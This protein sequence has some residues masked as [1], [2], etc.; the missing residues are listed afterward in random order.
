MLKEGEKR[1]SP[2]LDPGEIGRLAMEE[3]ADGVHQYSIGG[4]GVE[5]A[6]F[7][8]RQDPLD[9]TV[10]LVTGGPQ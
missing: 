2:R 4:S 7:F 8:E 1:Y 6:G 9:P 3:T 10:A 5:T